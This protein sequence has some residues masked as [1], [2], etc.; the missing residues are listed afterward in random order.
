MKYRICFIIIVILTMSEL[1]D[2]RILKTENTSSDT[3]WYSVEKGENPASITKKTYG[4]EAKTTIGKFLEENNIRDSRKIRIRTI[5]ILHKRLIDAEKLTQLLKEH[6]K[7]I[8]TK[9]IERMQSTQLILE[10]R[11]NE[12]KKEK[13]QIKNDS[14]A[15]QKEYKNLS[16]NIGWVIFISLAI[17]MGMF[18]L[19]RMYKKE[20]ETTKHHAKQYEEEVKIFERRL[21]ESHEQNIELIEALTQEKKKFKEAK[22][23]SSETKE[24][25]E[26]EMKRIEQALNAKQMGESA[27]LKKINENLLTAIGVV[28]REKNRLVKMTDDL[29]NKLDFLEKQ[30]PGNMITI[31][32]GKEKY[33]AIIVGWNLMDW[34]KK[35]LS[36]VARKYGSEVI[37]CCPECGELTP[38]IVDI[39][40]HWNEKHA[41]EKRAEILKTLEDA[42]KEKE[43]IEFI[44]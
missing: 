43:N 6:A 26:K 19:I 20:S 31:E 40:S 18:F 3:I 25:L 5:V 1:C 34:H 37:Y 8:Y 2:A 27:E 33:P 35:T 32:V 7:K 23:I 38:K 39:S 11:I 16:S 21:T 24:Q 4:Y 13:E 12:E 14:V 41:S 30:K 15:N 36:P 10:Q 9:E 28:Q 17:M 44:N 42:T 22:L 29:R